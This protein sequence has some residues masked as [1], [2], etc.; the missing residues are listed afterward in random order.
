[1]MNGIEE[2]VFLL[3]AMAGLALLARKLPIPYPIVLVIA[4][5]LLALI[6]GLPHVR[7][8]PDL[9]FLIFLPP[10]LSPAALFIPWRDFR[11][12]VRPILLLAIGLV[13]FTP[14]AVGSL[15]TSLLK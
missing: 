10:L 6:P 11:A 8:D 13:L 9:V 14:L 4:G 3:V 12:N 5:L 15:V 7:L 1:M 2:V